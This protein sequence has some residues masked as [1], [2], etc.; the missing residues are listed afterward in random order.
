MIGYV[1][2]ISMG[3]LSFPEINGGGVDGSKT[4]GKWGEG[5][6]GEEKGETE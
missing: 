4:E 6:G 2:L 3:G 1:L 5:L